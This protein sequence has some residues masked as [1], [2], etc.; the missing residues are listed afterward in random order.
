MAQDRP[1]AR[2][3]LDTVRAFLENLMPTLEDEARF[4]T[5]VS[6][7]LLEIVSRELELGGGLDREEQRALEALL[8][9]P[10]ELSAL[11]RELADGIR[12]GAL[13]AGSEEIFAHVLRCVEDK[14]RIVSPRRL[15]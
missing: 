3:A 15:P 6:I 5:R 1:S 4:H 7:H 2:N 13:D 9:H 10:G 11:N 8:G 14:L 12:S